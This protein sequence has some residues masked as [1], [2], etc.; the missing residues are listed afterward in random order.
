MTR[1]AERAK[2]AVPQGAEAELCRPSESGDPC[3]MTAT[4]LVDAYRRRSLSPVE[5][6]TR[7][8]DRIEAVNPRLNAYYEVDRPGAL[9]A[10]AAAAA[11]WRDGTPLGPLDGVPVSVK[12]HLQTRGLTNP[13]GAAAARP[14]PADFDC[15]PVARL[16]EGGAVILGKTT[17]PEL[18]V[19]PVT[20]SAAFGI[21]RNPWR[22][23][24]S[25]GGSSG[26]AAAAVAAG[27]GPLA[28]G[29]DGGGSIRLPAAFT[30]LVGLKPT[31]GRVPYFPGQTDRTVSGPIARNAADAALAMNVIARPDGRDWMELAPDGTDY[32]AALDGG[33]AGLRVAASPTFGFERIDPAVRRAFERGLERL[34]A[35]GARIDPVETIGFDVT[36]IYM[37]QAALRL[38]R[39]RD[40]MDP[41][42]FARRPAAIRSVLNFAAQLGPDD[43]QRMIDRRNE[44]GTALLAVFAKYQVVVSP[45]SPTPAP[46]IGKFYPDGDLL[47]ADSRNLIGFACPFNLVHMPAIGVPCG[48][49]ADGLPVGLQIAGPKYADALLLRAAHAFAAAGD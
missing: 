3:F 26:G 28:L 19:V 13:R 32:V 4:E 24:H 12:D 8:L 11:R 6:T 31:L 1:P 33:L 5:A 10:A 9:A 39:T 46:P 40:A 49:T 14:A 48:F 29:T 23:D 38:R 36:D 15:P 43:V 42:E 25:S 47:G 20:E 35:L 27:L 22:L 2:V 37:I 45:A 34:A 30:N 44:L 17:M 16:R 18:S 7:I 21:T 41:D